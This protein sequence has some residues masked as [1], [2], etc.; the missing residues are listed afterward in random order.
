MFPLT[1]FVKESSLFISLTLSYYKNLFQTLEYC[2]LL[3][4]R[5]VLLLRKFS[6]IFQIGVVWICI[7][8]W[9]LFVAG[10]FHCQRVRCITFDCQIPYAEPATTAAWFA[11]PGSA[12]VSVGNFPA[13]YSFSP[14]LVDLQKNWCATNAC[15]HRH[16]HTHI[17]IS[18]LLAC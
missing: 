8:N 12:K 18:L 11:R 6:C 17:Y 4:S 2:F 3:I 7:W 14:P 13:S 1:W 16:I 5:Q 10:F 9:Y 15:R